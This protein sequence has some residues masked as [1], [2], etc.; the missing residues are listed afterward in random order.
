MDQ[1]TYRRTLANLATGVT[2][3]TAKAGDGF[4]GMTASAVSRLSTEP[5]LVLVC[6]DHKRKLHGLLERGEVTGFCINVL[7]RT[8]EPLANHFASVQTLPADPFQAEGL[9]FGRTGAPIFP[10]VLS[11][12]DCRVA[13]RHPAGDH[14][15]YVG[16]VVDL[17]QESDS[18]EPLV[19]FRG[20]Y[21]S[22]KEA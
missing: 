8:Q 15:I 21:H 19:Y 14:T 4:H 9:R 17:N 11:W 10:G 16:E 3:V 7:A 6:V 22:V 5:P 1:R 12:L 18:A 20:K 2:V 13:A